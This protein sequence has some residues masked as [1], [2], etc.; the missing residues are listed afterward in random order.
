MM[1]GLEIWRRDKIKEQEQVIDKLQDINV[2][3][4]VLIQNVENLAHGR[5]ISRI[6][7]AIKQWR[8]ESK[9]QK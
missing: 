2:R 7:A 9:C 5:D 3:M 6:Q 4:R 1:T 8:K